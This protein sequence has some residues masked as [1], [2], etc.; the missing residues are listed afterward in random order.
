MLPCFGFAMAMALV[1]L[2]LPL[3][4]AFTVL[5]GLPQAQE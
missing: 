5:L 3:F 4:S 1:S 2:P